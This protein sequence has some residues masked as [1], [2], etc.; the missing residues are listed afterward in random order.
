MRHKNSLDLLTYWNARRGDRPAPAR[1]E[2]EPSA[3]SAMLPQVFIAERTGS[4]GSLVFRLAGTAI[5]LLMGR[6]LKTT[7]LAELWLSEGRRNAASLAG[8]VTGGTPCVLSLD[9]LSAGG[10]VIGAE[11]LLL[12]VTGP[13]GQPD[14][15]FGALSV[16]DPPYWIGYDPLAGLSTTGIRF[17]DMDRE[18]PFIANR[19]EIAVPQPVRSM[20]PPPLFGRRKIGHL[21]V[22]DGGRE[23]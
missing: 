2:M 21:T 9:G 16:F 13:S 7:P 4:D 15:V 11:M 17:L 20:A 6:E 10:R 5:C 12:P 3:I 1:V 18:A 19:P 22:M 23:D 14:R 8:A